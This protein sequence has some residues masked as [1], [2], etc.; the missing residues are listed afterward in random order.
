MPK[1]KIN[2]NDFRFDL[3]VRID[4]RNCRRLVIRL[5]AGLGALVVLATKLASWLSAVAG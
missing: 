2:S 5:A 3:L 4:A 1:K